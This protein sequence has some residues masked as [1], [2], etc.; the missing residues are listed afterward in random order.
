MLVEQALY[1]LPSFVPFLGTLVS[2]AA[3]PIAFI[4]VAAA[5]SQLTASPSPEIGAATPPEVL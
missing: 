2:F 3:M 1:L 5:Y 4:L